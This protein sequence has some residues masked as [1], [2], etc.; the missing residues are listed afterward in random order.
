M[1]LKLF[2][3]VLA[4]GLA[5][6]Q[7]GAMAQQ[8]GAPLP[9][10]IALRPYQAPTAL[11][12]ADWPKD[13]LVKFADELATF[14]Y[15]H[16][17]VKDKTRKMYGY[18]YEF[19]RDGRQMQTKGLDSMHDGF[20][21]LGGM[22]SAHRA[23]PHGKFLDHVQQWQVPFY[24]TVL[25][26]SDVVFPSK[27][28]SPEDKKDYV[29][30]LKG[31]I[32]RDWEDGQGYPHGKAQPYGDPW[33][34]ISSNHLFQDAFNI[35]MDA[36]MTTR[37]PAVAEAVMH[38]HQYK[39]EYYGPV[40][41]FDFPAGVVSNDEK[42]IKQFGALPKATVHDYAP[43]YN[44]AYLQNEVSLHTYDDALAWY[45][46]HA[47]ANYLLNGNIDEAF[48]RKCLLRT[49]GT[50]HSMEVYYDSEPWPYG[51]IFFDIQRPPKFVKGEG[52]LDNY[53]SQPFKLFGGRGVQ[54]V[55]TAAAVLP[56]LVKHPEVWEQPYREKY[57]GEPLVR[58][59]DTPPTTDGKKDAIYAKSQSVTT[60]GTMVTAIS[61]PKNLHLLVE[62]NAPSVTLTLK[63][64]LPDAAR[65]ATITLAK[66]GTVTAV[67]D[68][69]AALLHEAKCTAG[70]AW[71]A[72]IRLPYTFMR[73]QAAWINGVENGR[74]TLTVNGESK[75]LYLLSEP[76]RVVKKLE[77]VI[78]GTI[79]T[80]ARISEEQGGGI[81]SGYHPDPKRKVRS[82]EVSDSGNIG[83]VISTVA[84]WSIYQQGKN[85]W[86]I[87]K[88]NFPA[89]P[90]PAKPL[91]AEVLK[92]LG[93]Q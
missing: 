15:D 30:P 11:N 24:T 13:R 34:D 50:F 29:E 58:M 86:E 39:R 53:F 52:R 16:H 47:I 8:E 31:W 80:L 66:D 36:W 21:F 18:T 64:A 91:P 4:L 63:H 44:G 10:E 68:Q 7:A 37:D 82:W 38:M 89:K 75:T 35:L 43:M 83:H 79:D 23:F 45:Y 48:I 71:I 20:W 61:D 26:H 9:E 62:S 90:M 56:Y 57:D 78:L 70:N 27:P 81:P 88:A 41:T 33:L 46:R 12:P 74:Y 49:L 1:R 32:P 92:L 28:R 42:L 5:I 84:L 3:V 77:A 22:L 2:C 55:W 93:V 67:N 76:A 54:M 60:G 14:V 17:V 40:N 87:L 25:N 73:G 72:E 51:M 19:Y 6:F 65:T 59:V 85:E 69:G